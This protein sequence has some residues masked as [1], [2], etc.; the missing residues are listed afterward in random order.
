MQPV[1]RSRRAISS[2]A[3]VDC[4]A[5]RRGAIVG[6]VARSGLSLLSLIW[7]LSSLSLSL[8]LFPQM[9][10]REN[11][12]AQSFPGQRWKYWSTGSHFPWQ[13]NMRIWGKMIS[14]NHFTQNKRTLRVILRTLQPTPKFTSMCQLLIRFQHFQVY[15]VDS[16]ESVKIQSG[17]DT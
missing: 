4:A 16:Y 6:A 8:S 3:I 7:A 15:V 9:I 11:E 13:P 10:W 2:I 5:R 1:L 12:G 17:V 14:W